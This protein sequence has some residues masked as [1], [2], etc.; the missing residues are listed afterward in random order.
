MSSH[1]PQRRC[2][3]GGTPGPDGECAACK[4]A[5]L[6]RQ[7]RSAAATPLPTIAPSIVHEVLQSSGQPMDTATRALFEP[8]LGH[9]FSRV[10]VH[11]DARAAE[12]ARE[13]DAQAYTVGWDVVFGAG[14]YAPGTN[15]GRRLLAHE[16]AHVVQQSS[17]PVAPPAITSISRADSRVEH[18]AA[19]TGDAVA[20]GGRVSPVRLAVPPGQLARAPQQATATAPQSTRPSPQRLRFDI[21]GADL[22]VTDFIARAAAVAVDADMRVTS[23]D[24]MINK[25]EVQASPTS[26][27]CL[28]HIAIWNHG[29]PGL[30]VVAGEEPICVRDVHA[31]AQ[32]G[33]ACPAGYRV[34][35]LPRTGFDLDWLLAPGNQA[36]LIR[37]RGLFCCNGSMD[38]LGCGTAGVE[39]AG[40]LRT[41]AERGQTSATQLRYGTY[42]DRYE[43]MQDALAHGASPLGATFGRL[44]VQ[45]WA[46]ATCTTINASN[47]FTYF[48][49]GNPRQLYQ[50]GHG[51]R[52]VTTP[53]GAAGHCACDPATGR[54][55]G[56]WTIAEETRAITADEQTLTGPEY[57]WHAHL[58]LFREL[59]GYRN[60]AEYEHQLVDTLHLLLEDVAPGV[61]IPG[62]LP[63]GPMRPW[64]NI[65][66]AN[67]DWAAVTTPFLALCFPDNCWRWIMVNQ[68][69]IETTL[70]FTQ[71]VLNHELL[72]AVDVR[73]AAQEYR[74]TH[75]DPPTGAGDRCRPAA[76][77]TVQGWTDPWGTYMRDFDAFYRG[78][79][80]DT[81]HVD[82]Y[83]L[84]AG[85]R[86]NRLTLGERLDWFEAVMAN[87]PANLPAGRTFE[88]E[89]VVLR[90]FRNPEPQE[91]ALRQEMTDHLGRRAAVFILGDS[92]G[93]SRDI[94]KG[95]SLLNH[96]DPLWR[97]IGTQRTLL[98]QGLQNARP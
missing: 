89:Q 18:E 17:G 59:L 13:V 64:I 43:S 48:N 3:C 53:P 90:L 68:Q 15:E 25:L 39:A 76:E 22:S 55:Q 5:R 49:P 94:G 44:N 96:F 95:R 11:T 36:A 92:R 40:G 12:S 72:H 37:L 32:P 91:L 78:G 66:T 88:A 75:G 54:V 84:S 26:G 46:D 60:R 8:R 62:G 42:G 58:R 38:W 45:G 33:G 79:L 35:R 30:Q 73:R 6:A 23:L 9:E 50:V 52:F 74:R 51:G 20:A 82:I 81:R 47:D 65:A 14:R 71:V 86:F 85:P 27:R 19:A 61:A 98:W 31:S 70:S 97:P 77:A 4:S 7:R 57:L 34:T 24:D 63:V 93:Q 87:I 69:A 80:A 10:R 21:L 56:A 1:L 28:E 16:L 83:G 41:S 67:P 29:K 2:A